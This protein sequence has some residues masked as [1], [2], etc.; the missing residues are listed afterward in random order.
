MSS[1]THSYELVSV[2]LRKV[3]FL[4]VQ[5]FN[6][7]ASSRLFHCDKRVRRANLTGNR[8][9]IQYSPLEEG[10]CGHVCIWMLAPVCVGVYK[11]VCRVMVCCLSLITFE[12]GSSL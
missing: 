6:L 1:V 7:M 5:G 4:E 8:T 10:V 12:K 2:C 3:E 9:K 11:C